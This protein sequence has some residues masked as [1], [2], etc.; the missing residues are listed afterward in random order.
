[1]IPEVP[2]E[3]LFDDY[4]YTENFLAQTYSH[5]QSRT[6]HATLTN[7]DPC[8][9]AEIQ[10]MFIKMSRGVVYNQKFLEKHGLD[11]YLKVPMSVE[12][13]TIPD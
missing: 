7:E 3:K 11:G 8:K 10:T 9:L 6:E 2:E 13:Y 4:P 1:M 5:A 12:S